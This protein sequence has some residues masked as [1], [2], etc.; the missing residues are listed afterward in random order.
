MD[1]AELLPSAWRRLDPASWT[2][3][4]CLYDELDATEL[5]GTRAAVTGAA[6]CAD[7]C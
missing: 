5:S 1:I 6:T 7:A 2:Q 3:P 4:L